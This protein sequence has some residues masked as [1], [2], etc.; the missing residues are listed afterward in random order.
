M[1]EERII[2]RLADTRRGYLPV[3][4][5]CSPNRRLGWISDLRGPGE[6][7]RPGSLSFLMT[8]VADLGASDALSVEPAEKIQ[9]E[10]ADIIDYRLDRREITLAVK[11]AH[12]TADEW[13]R[14]AGFIR[15]EAI[16]G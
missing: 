14:V 2:N 3:H 15:D 11:S 9:T 13:G 16:L 8:P 1:S 4:C 12:R 5:C 6:W 7:G 10:A